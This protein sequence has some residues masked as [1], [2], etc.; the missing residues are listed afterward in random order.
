MGQEQIS[1][2]ST[3]DF[4]QASL[5]YALGFPLVGLNRPSGDFV[6][7]TFEDPEFKGEILLDEYW[8]GGVMVDAKKLISS[9]KELKNRM[10]SRMQNG[11]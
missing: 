3:K 10:Y 11:V 7:F 6:V 9:I 1:Q 4:Y 8:N 2:I 5:L